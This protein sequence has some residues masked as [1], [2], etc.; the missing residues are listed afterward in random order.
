MAPCTVKF[1]AYVTEKCSGW[2]LDVLDLV[3]SYLFFFAHE[4]LMQLDNGIQK[5]EEAVSMWKMNE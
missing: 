1:G 3:G 4:E 5:S 2:A